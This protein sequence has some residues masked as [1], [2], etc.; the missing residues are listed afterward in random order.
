[1]VTNMSDWRDKDDVD[2]TAE[3]IDAMIASGESIRI[4]GSPLPGMT[5]TTPSSRN[6][7]VN[8]TVVS[9]QTPDLAGLRG[10]LVGSDTRWVGIFEDAHVIVHIADFINTDLSAKLN[11]V[12][13]GFTVAGLAGQA[14]DGQWFSARHFVAASVEVPGRYTGDDIPVSLELRDETRD[15]VVT[16]VAPRHLHGRRDEVPGAEPLTIGRLA[17]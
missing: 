3:D 9:E 2:L 10:E 14:P 13:G 17:R 4:V 7:G 12:G 6:E 11:V 8:F 16:G 5:V 15:E 1:M